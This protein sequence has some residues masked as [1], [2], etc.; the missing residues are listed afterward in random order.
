MKSVD[1]RTCGGVYYVLGI[2]FR[3]F[4]PLP[5]SPPPV[6]SGPL[7]VDY[8]SAKQGRVQE[9][10]PCDLALARGYTLQAWET[11]THPRC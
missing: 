6:P 8:L 5:C 1:V 2:P 10:N 9:R 3:A 4:T 7:L 11:A